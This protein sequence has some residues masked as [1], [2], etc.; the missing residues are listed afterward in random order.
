MAIVGHE[1][2]STAVLG[3]RHPDEVDPIDVEMVGRFVEDQEVGGVVD[4]GSRESHSARL[5]T[6]E[7]VDEATI[8]ARQAETIEGSTSPPV[9]ADDLADGPACV[10]GSLP[11]GRHAEVAPAANLTSLGAFELG[12]DAQQRRLSRAVDPDDSDAFSVGDRE[13]EVV[14]ERLG[15]VERGEAIDVEQ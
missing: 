6:R 12:K 1:D 7:V 2:D 15:R 9:V 4:Q 5:A 11:H 13:R 8:E 10:L 3:E 14:E